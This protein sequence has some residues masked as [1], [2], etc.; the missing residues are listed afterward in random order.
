MQ[1]STTDRQRQYASLANHVYQELLR[2]RKMHAPMRGPHEGY[3]VLL[4]EVDEL[5][6]EVKA[7]TFD[8]AAA[9]KEALQVAAMALAFAVEVCDEPTPSAPLRSADEDRGAE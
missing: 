9:R 3:A 7:K 4:E 2:A 5:W 6:S 1:H 8:K